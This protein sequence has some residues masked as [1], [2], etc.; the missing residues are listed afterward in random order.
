[1][2]PRGDSF[3]AAA[4]HSSSLSGGGGR[5]R[6]N[7]TDAAHLLAADLRALVAIAGVDDSQLP[8]PAVE[9]PDLPPSPKGSGSG[10]GLVGWG[11]YAPPA[12]S[13]SASRL[14]PTASPALSSPRLSAASGEGDDDD[15][16][17]DDGRGG[18]WASLAPLLR[19]SSRRCRR[20]RS[21]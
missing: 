7:S 14:S 11:K 1:M 2:S 21:S 12:T 10:G 18:V 8:P 15:G 20:R 5:P 6:N 13:P 4:L 19:S 16:A 17:D 3:K 9:F